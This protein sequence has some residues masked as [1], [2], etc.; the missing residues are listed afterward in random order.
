MKKFVYIILILA[1]GALAYYGTKEPSGR[2]EKNEEDQHAVSGMSEKLAGD[3]NEA[4]LTL[5]VNGSEV[6]E[7][8]YKPYV[9][10]NLHLMMPLKMLKDKMKCTY[11]EYVNGSIVI[12]RNEG[13]A[14]LVLDSQDAELDGKDVKIADAPIKK[15]DETFVPIEYIA[16]TLDYT[17]EYNYDTGRV[18]L[19]KVGEDSKLPAAYDM[20]KEGRVTEVRDQGD[21]GTCWAFASLAALE[22]TLM[23][24]EKLQF[25]VDNMT[26]NNGFGVEQFEGGQYRMSIAYLA[27]WKGPV[28]EKDDPYGDDKTNS[29][30]KAV[31]HLQEAE[32]I[33][34][35]NLKAVKEAVYTKGGVETAIYSD[36][37]D[38]DSSSE[39]YNEET[40]AYYYD[41]S[42]GINHDV[43]IVGWDDNYSKNNFN[44]APKK[45]GAFICK[46]SW[47]TEFGEDGYFYISYYDAHICETSVVYTRLEGADNYDKIYQSDKLGWVGVLGFDQEDAYFANVYTAGKSEE[48]KAVSFYATDA[49]TTYEVY[50]ATN[51]EDTDDLANKKLVA[52]G[53]MEYAGYYTVNLDD[54]VKL[55]DEKK[56]AVIVH[57]TTPG[58]KYP[59]AIEYDADSMT[60]SFDI[61]DGEGYIS[62]YG[63]QWYSAEKERKCNVCLKAFTDKTE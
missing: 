51:F 12:K 45:E 9:S 2:L 56:F 26:M 50:V 21:S 10:N 40:H 57:I 42:E 31:K 5:Y 53:E 4:G 62:L 63:N 47:G 36:M 18:S 37:I 32:I 52:S 54:V 11:I 29:K 8:E 1:I 41:G 38:A 59:I 49:K 60:D 34:D 22:T 61:S 46:N 44:K 25:S 6:E 30:L 19:Q 55:P 58:S 3:Y 15:D 24:D 39:Y 35:K 16:D 28:L 33:D 17:C 20:R 7:D 27:S 43:V 23:P 48:L 14:R 13:V